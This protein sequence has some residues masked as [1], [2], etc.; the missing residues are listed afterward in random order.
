MWVAHDQWWN[1]SLDDTLML[2][3]F[4]MTS[5][6]C[7]KLVYGCI[8]VYLRTLTCIYVTGFAKTRHN[9]TRTEIHFI[10]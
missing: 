3:P 10:A 4:H 6:I 8:N 1:A 5:Y 7:M 2:L 9:V